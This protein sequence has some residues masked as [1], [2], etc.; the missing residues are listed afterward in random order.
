M[1]RDLGMCTVLEMIN[2]PQL[3]RIVD[4]RLSFNR[5]TFWVGK[6]AAISSK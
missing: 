4:F 3:Y 6:R 5:A 1:K 2:M